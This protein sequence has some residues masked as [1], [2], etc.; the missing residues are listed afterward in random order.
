MR[1]IDVINNIAEKTGIQKV[2]VLVAM[3]AFF[4]EIKDSLSRGENVYVRGFGSFI[5]KKR[6][7]KIGRNITRN[8][9]LEIPE[10]VIPA[11]KPAK[12]F[13]EQ[14]KESGIKDVSQ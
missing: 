11:F 3:E 1:K 10:H 5:V 9:A 12:I 14:V 13:V 4:Q 2:D 8:I 6:A 7:K